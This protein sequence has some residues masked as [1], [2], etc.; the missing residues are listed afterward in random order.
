MSSHLRQ[1]SGRRHL[2]R[3][4]VCRATV[5]RSSR[6]LDA[7]TPLQSSRK[8]IQKRIRPS[9]EPK[10]Q[11]PRKSFFTAT[12]GR[13]LSGAL[14]LTALGSIIVASGYACEFL[15]LVKFWVGAAIGMAIYGLVYTS[16]WLPD[17]DD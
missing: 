14:H 3:T 9:L 5:K 13:R 11:I 4:L 1:P 16:S 6:G 17:N 8:I 10:D 12:T 15:L 2:A 7:R